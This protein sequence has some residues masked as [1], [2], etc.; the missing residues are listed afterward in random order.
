M[1]RD[2]HEPLKLNQFDKTFD[3]AKYYANRQDVFRNLI[4]FSKRPEASAARESVKQFMKLSIEADNEA[5]REFI[6]VCNEEKR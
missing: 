6:N 3:T 1:A 4:R 5:A 2:R